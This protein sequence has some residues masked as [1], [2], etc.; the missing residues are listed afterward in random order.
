ML[1]N[2]VVRQESANLESFKLR[3]APDLFFLA[4]PRE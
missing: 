1:P 4:N 2:I 3:A